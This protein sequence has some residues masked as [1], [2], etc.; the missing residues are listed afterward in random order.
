V[1]L[2]HGLA[3]QWRGVSH[4]KLYRSRGEIADGAIRRSATLRGARLIQAAAQ[5]KSTGRAFVVHAYEVGSRSGLLESLSNY[6]A[7]S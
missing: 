7:I 4:V 1:G 3:L 6:C 2:H 5:G